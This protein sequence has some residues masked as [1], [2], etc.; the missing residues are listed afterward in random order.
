M[1]ID[2][3]EYVQDEEDTVGLVIWEEQAW[4][5]SQEIPVVDFVV[6]SESPKV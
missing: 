4:C 2:D 3:R 1:I 6:A 5:L